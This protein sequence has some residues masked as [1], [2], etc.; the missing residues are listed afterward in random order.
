M[1]QDAG[2]R[3]ALVDLARLAGADWAVLQP[4]RS[5]RDGVGR[6]VDPGLLLAVERGR[7]VRIGP[8]VL[9]RW[10]RTAGSGLR[11]LLA[12][13]DRERP[14][15]RVLAGLRHDRAVDL[16]RI[17][18]F[19]RSLLECEARATDPIA[20]DGPSRFRCATHDLCHLLTV[21]SLEIE[22]ARLEGDAEEAFD[23]AQAAVEDARNLCEAVLDPEPAPGRRRRYA[24]RLLLESA[25]RQAALAS[26]RG[27]RVEVRIACE[28]ELSADVDRGLL[29]RALRNLLLNAI[30]AS[31][32]GARVT[33]AATPDGGGGIRVS[34]RDE[35]RGIA[36]E[37]LPELLRPGRTA[38]GGSGYGTES[39]RAS[40]RELGGVLT[41]RSRPFAGTEVIVGLP[42]ARG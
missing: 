11:G 23:R 9:R 12:F 38:T 16:D 14:A 35:G 34:V 2:I 33:L 32:D 27:D 41:V 39:V 10:P 30:E 42:G 26:G 21:A 4:D 3:A 19:A 20:P 37:D 17:E 5:S 29:E 6:D 28:P 8:R 1:K 22:R 13:V 18:P 31:P 15:R 24:V 25:A 36:A 40:V 7:L